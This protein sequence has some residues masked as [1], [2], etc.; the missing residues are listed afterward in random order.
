MQPILLTFALVL[1]PT[2]FAQSV[3]VQSAPIATVEWPKNDAARNVL[4]ESLLNTF[5]AKQRAK[6]AGGAGQLLQTGFQ[7]LNYQG[8]IDRAGELAAIAGAGAGTT[9][10]SDVHAT[11]VGDALIVTCLATVHETVGGVKLPTDETP[12]MSVWTWVDGAWRMAAF[13][14]LNMPQ[15]RP[16]PGAP[17]SA[18]DSATNAIGETLLKSFI[19]AQVNKDLTVFN[20][21]LADGMQSVNFKGQKLRDDLIKGADYAKSETP[22]FAA[23][24]GTQCGDLTIVTCNLTL[25]QKIGWSTLP[26]ASA[27]FMVVFQGA[28]SLAKVIATTNTN[29]PV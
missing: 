9:K 23:I 28:G 26:A 3:P 2:A 15:T 20:A 24:R 22:V 17:N 29:K 14:S 18:G 13:G 6:D 4:G 5:F 27:P 21:M 8:S 19:N 11:R 16:A 1:S 10:I 7:A 25:G 12:R